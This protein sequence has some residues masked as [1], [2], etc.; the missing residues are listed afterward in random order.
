LIKNLEDSLVSLT[1]SSGTEVGLWLDARKKE[2]DLMSNMPLIRSGNKQAIIDYLNAEN[3]RNK[4]YEQFFI[5]DEQGDYFFNSGQK[6]SVADREYFK[7]VM[8]T[9][10]AAISHPLISRG[11]GNQII[12][13]AS[14][15]IKEDKPVGL[16]GGNVSLEE[17]SRMVA[18]VKIGSIGYAFIVQDNGLFIAHPEPSIIMKYNPLTDSSADSQF[19]S[20]IS[21]MSAGESGVARL[22]FLEEDSYLAY[23]PVEGVK[24]ALGVTVPATYITNQVRVLPLVYFTSVYWA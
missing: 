22:Q 5:A 21:N 10:K 4:I 19:S 20:A 23:A 2:M 9:G 11:S 17:L 7:K 16:I 6:G 3:D 14:P 1:A 12:V 15:I 24:W 18:S 8:S 13:V